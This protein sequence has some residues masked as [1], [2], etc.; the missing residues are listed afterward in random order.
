M[1]ADATRSSVLRLVG[2]GLSDY[3]IA[4]RTGVPRSTVWH[5]RTDAVHT[6]IAEEAHGGLCELFPDSRVCR[7][8]HAIDR[9]IELQVSHPSLP[10]AF[11]Q[12]GPGKKHERAIELV[13]WQCELT[14]A[15][16]E[17]LIRGLIH[18][19]GCRTVN[20]FSTRLPSG[21]IGH[22]EYPRY[23]FSNLSADIRRIFCEHCE[24]LGIHWT[25][26][27]PRNVSISHRDSVAILDSFV[28]PKS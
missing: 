5:W 21:R 26:S 12:C 7:Y 11:P 24:L 1:H 20:R 10:Y 6:Q 16:P 4:R 8:R 15:N 13:G 9:K 22:Y 14:H 18:S 28:G 3:E 2:S 23:F 17:Q 25:L 27:N 19:D